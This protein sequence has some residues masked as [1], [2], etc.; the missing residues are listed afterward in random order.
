MNDSP[1]ILIVPGSARTGSWNVKLAHAAA[2]RLATLGAQTTVIDLRA[3]GL[4]IYDGDLEAASGVPA[5]A[6]TLVAEFAAH[7]GVLIVSP[8]YNAHPT[9]LFINAIDWATRL[10]EHKAAMNGKPT[11]MLA[12]SPGALGG[13]RSLLVLRNFL[14][15]N[16]GMLVLPQQY[17]LSQAHAA[18]AVDGTLTDPKQQAMLDVVLTALVKAAQTRSG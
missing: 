16:P 2:G 9:P 17:A 11:A 7:D 8:E 6:S 3:L 18:F 1:R 4:P 13:L 10:P 5:G 14:S 15:I 12:A